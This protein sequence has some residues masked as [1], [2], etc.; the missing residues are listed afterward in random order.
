MNNLLVEGQTSKPNRRFRTAPKNHSHP[1]EMAHLM[2]G[3]IMGVE[4]KWERG[5]NGSRRH[6]VVNR[7]PN[8]VVPYTFSSDFSTLIY[9]KNYKFNSV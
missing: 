1:F 4:G 7:W 6:F 8:G 9:K 5:K 2:Q 3:D